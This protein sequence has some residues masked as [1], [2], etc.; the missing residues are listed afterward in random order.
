MLVASVSYDDKN[1]QLQLANLLLEILPA[2]HRPV[3]VM[4]I[5][6]DRVTGDSFGPLVGTFLRGFGLD[7]LGTL[8]EPVHAKNL[9]THIEQVD[10]KFFVLAIDA[11]LGSLHSIGKI[12]VY[13]GPITP[14]SGVGKKLEAVGEAGI[15]MT[16]NVGGFMENMVLANTRLSLVYSGAQ[17][18]AL[19]IYRALQLRSYCGHAKLVTAR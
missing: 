5:G 7:P 10:A 17:T 14:G 18:T 9:S 3:K 6:T 8:E 4:C 11:C 12:N 1:A 15:T 19:A 13:R 16:V 2:E